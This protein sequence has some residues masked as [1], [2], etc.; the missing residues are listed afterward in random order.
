[1]SLLL[2]WAALAVLADPALAG[3]ALTAAHAAARAALP[4][5]MH[6]V[7]PARGD[8]LSAR[9]GQPAA[10]SVLIATLIG[11]V[12][13]TFMLGLAA[14]AIGIILVVLAGFLMA[15][16]S[17]RQIGGQTGDVLGALEQVMEIVILLVAVA[18]RG[19]PQ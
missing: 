4:A 9:A 13:L 8:G 11:V 17:L 3:A 2:R 12:T 15:R 19:I 1:M 10:S 7:P 18:T 6:L 5:F 16:L 14:A